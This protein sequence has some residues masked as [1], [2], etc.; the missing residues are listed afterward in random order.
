[1][2]TLFL[3]KNIIW[4]MQIYF[5]IDESGNLD[6]NEKIFLFGRLFFLN[7][8]LKNKCLNIYRNSELKILKNK[9]SKE[10]KGTSLNKKNHFSLYKIIENEKKF[11]AHINNFDD[12]KNL[13]NKKEKKNYK[14]EILI[15]TIYNVILKNK[16][17]INKNES[18]NFYIILDYQNFSK[19][20]ENVFNKKLREELNKIFNTKNNLKIKYV[21]SRHHELIRVADILCNLTRKRIKKDE[22]I[23]EK[24][25]TYIIF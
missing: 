18:N 22:K 14:I 10:L 24:N 12:I 17:Y 3:I 1:M 21:D 7:E 15:K 16:E 2:S 19:D 13:K 20:D 25:L 5:Y 4:K 8:E 9:K 11:I 6:K 23:E